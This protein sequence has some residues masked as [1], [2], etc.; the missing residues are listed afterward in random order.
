VIG[1]TCFTREGETA[2]YLFA[3][4]LVS[5]ARELYGR[6]SGCQSKFTLILQ[7]RNRRRGGVN[8]DNGLLTDLAREVNCGFADPLRFVR[9]L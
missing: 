5:N 4:S 9:L 7:P 8:D 2:T 3:S 6:L 1:V